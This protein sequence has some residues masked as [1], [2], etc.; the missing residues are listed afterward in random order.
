MTRAC[1][2]RL[3]AAAVVLAALPAARADNEPKKVARPGET[4]IEVKL[5]DDSVIKL[6]LLDLSVEFVTPHGKL[7]IPVSEIRRVELGLRIP[8]DAATIIRAA[9]ADL[10]SPQFRKREEAMATLLKYREKSYGALKEAAK[11]SDAET[12]KR[13]EELIEKLE[14]I[15]PRNRLETP[16]YDVIHTDLSKI[17]GKIVAPTLRARSF[18]FGEVPLKLSDVVAMSANGFKDREELVQALPDPGSLTAYQQPQHIGK[19]FVFTVTGRADGNLWGTGTYTLDSTLAMA[20][21]HAGVLK[22]GQT[23]NVKVTILPAMAG[24]VGSTQNGI[25][26][27]PYAQYPGAYQIHTKER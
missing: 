26:S 1:L 24:F 20:A 10:G 6:T 12:A 14:A 3:L 2:A 7:T 18:T 25:T 15:V 9:A 19:T 17:A 5:I 27:Q 8:D 16:D 21:V 11:S 13:A 22:I 23:G 4:A